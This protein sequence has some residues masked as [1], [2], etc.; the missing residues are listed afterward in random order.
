MGEE[1]GR[2]LPVGRR[3]PVHQERIQGLDG[4]VVLSFTA[5]NEKAASKEAAFFIWRGASVA[6]GPEGQLNR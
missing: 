1:A 6:S 4:P 5:A 3:A 2:R